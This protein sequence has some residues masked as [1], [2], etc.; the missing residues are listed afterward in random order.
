M[1]VL[2]AVSE[3]ETA[4][5]EDFARQYPEVAAEISVIRESLENYAFTLEKPAPAS[6]K[7]NL[8]KNLFARGIQPAP[9]LIS[10][11]PQI[12]RLVWMPYAMAASFLAFMMSVGF[13]F[14]LGGRLEKTQQKLATLEARNQ[15]MAVTLQTSRQTAQAM[16]G[17]IEF[18][19]NPGT[20]MVMLKGMEKAKNAWI[21]VYWNRD[22]KEL[23]LAQHDLPP[24]PA[25][26]Q[27]QVW[28]VMGGKK[29]DAGMLEMTSGLQGLK[30]IP[31]AQ[32]FVITLE[33]SGGNIT[34]TG[35]MY[36]MGNV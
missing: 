29:M 21:A 16:A 24:P 20:K 11:P 27:Y 7:E 17:K 8:R 25:G 4:E 34:P 15:E 14:M 12:R 26:M 23:M 9:A 28:A 5:V 2:G 10:E 18:I 36:A 33:K 35:E 22:K 19:N 32:A 1:Y 3:Q 30:S 6:V 31:E 13:N